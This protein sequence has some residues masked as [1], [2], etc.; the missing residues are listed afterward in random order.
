M[1]DLQCANS[2]ILDRIYGLG[3]PNVVGARL[4]HGTESA[5]GGGEK[6]E[7]GRFGTVNGVGILSK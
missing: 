2:G 4:F 1:G 5:E 7:T 6:S 3:L